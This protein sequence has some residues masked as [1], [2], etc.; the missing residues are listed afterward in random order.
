VDGKES[1][2]N[3]SA[4]VRARIEPG[5]MRGAEAIL[6]KVGLTPSEAITLFFAQVT[7]HKGLPFPVR[8]PNRETK[9]ALREALT[10]KNLERFDSVVEW[11]RKM[12]AL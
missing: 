3:K 10:G 2:M 1:A 5:L 8:I 4:T 9:R 6:K 11:K 7:L 12:R